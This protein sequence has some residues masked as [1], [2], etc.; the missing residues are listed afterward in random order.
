MA[1]LS[2]RFKHAWNAFNER[3]E[4]EKVVDHNQS[5]SSYRP[6]RIQP[7]I[8]SDRSMIRALYN[9]IAIDVAAVPIKHVRENADHQMQSEIIS[10]FNSVLNLSAN[11]DQTG[12]A[13]I[14]DIAMSLC[15]EGVIAVV[16]TE[17]SKN[18]RYTDSYDIFSMRVGK[19]IEW[20]PDKVK[21]NLYD[22]RV[23]RHKEIVVSKNDAAII[24]N[25]LYEVMN[26]PNS[27]I[28]RL[29]HKLT[30]LDRLDERGASGKL[31]L[32]IQL[33]YVVKT[34]SKLVQAES[35]R[36]QIEDQL[37]NSKY[38][39]AYIDGSEKI[40]QLN[41]SLE[42]N[43]LAQIEYL[44]KTLYGQL[45]ITEEVFNGTADE[46][47][48]LNYYNRTIEPILAAITDEF[49]RK[50]LTPTARTQ[51]QSIHYVRQPFRL[52]PVDQVAEIADKFTRNAVL[53]PNEIRSI[54]GYNPVADSRADELRNRN[55][56]QADAEIG[57]P[58]STNPEGQE[59]EQQDPVQGALSRVGQTEVLET[60]GESSK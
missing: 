20:Y 24:Q 40:V 2:E 17:T 18:P 27:T 22:E 57:D 15:D 34:E 52:V 23:G 58:V 3:S 32:L 30:L 42:N 8:I 26:E 28:K 21:V 37:V 44:T 33:P 54:M 60:K 50:F 9:R 4:Y 11:L 49:K 29:L 13:F 25:P 16:P 47:T 51:G 43:L 7:F 53:S 39:I 55:L 41:K 46:K 56:N 38:G 5:V 45:G 19:I 36:K 14:Q 35:R 12:R 6:D 31:D 48:M 1:K 59:V 10:D